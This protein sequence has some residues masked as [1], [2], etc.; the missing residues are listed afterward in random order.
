MAIHFF[1][2][3]IKRPKLKYR[4]IS[5]WIKKIITSNHKA[6]GDITYIFCTNSYLLNINQQFLQHDYFTDIITFDYVENDI[7]SGDI[8]ISCEMVQEN[9]SKYGVNLEEEFLRVISHGVLHLLG[10]KDKTNEEKRLM[11]KKEE[12]SI[13]LYKEI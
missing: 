11:R 8:Y 5:G 6:P 12:E 10:Y 4:L 7:I 9:S 1:E 2:E 3:E 13:L